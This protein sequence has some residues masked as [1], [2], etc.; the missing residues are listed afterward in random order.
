MVEPENRTNES[1]IHTNEVTAWIATAQIRFNS[2]LEKLASIETGEDM[3]QK[4]IWDAAY[5]EIDGHQ[6]LTG[7]C[8][9]ED[10]VSAVGL[11]VKRNLGFI[12]NL[13]LIDLYFDWRI[14]HQLLGFTVDEREFFLDPTYGQIAKEPNRFLFEHIEAIEPYYRPSEMRN[15]EFKPKEYSKL[16]V[17]INRRTV[18]SIDYLL[19]VIEGRISIDE[20]ISRGRDEIETLLDNIIEGK[21]K[22]LSFEEA[23]SRSNPDR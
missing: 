3:K 6:V 14:H 23:L 7:V 8:W 12:R 22:G 20:E 15:R 10:A 2:G 18:S 13:K 5:E 16:A 4:G 9:C 17:I 1:G 19:G 21:V 11:A